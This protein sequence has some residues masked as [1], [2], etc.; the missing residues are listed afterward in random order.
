MD[1]GKYHNQVLFFFRTLYVVGQDVIF[2]LDI[3]SFK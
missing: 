3:Q 2:I 1:K